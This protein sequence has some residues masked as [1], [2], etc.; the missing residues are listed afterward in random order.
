MDTIFMKSTN[1]QIKSP[2]YVFSKKINPYKPQ[3]FYRNLIFCS[4]AEI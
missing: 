4:F 2:Y 3:V 1:L